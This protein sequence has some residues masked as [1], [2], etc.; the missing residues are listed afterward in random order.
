NFDVAAQLIQAGADLTI[1]NRE[2]AVIHASGLSADVLQLLL[3]AGADV[4]ARNQVG[5]TA[6]HK[7]RFNFEMTGLLLAAGADVS[8]QDNQGRTPLFDVN[9]KVAAQLI[10]AGADVNIQDS[11]GRTPLHQA[12]LEEGSYFGPE[13]VKLFLSKGAIADVKDYQGE[14]A[15]DIARRL[16]K[17]TI[18]QLFPADGGTLVN[19]GAANFEAA[20]P[21]LSNRVQRQVESLLQSARA[22]D[23]PAEMALSQLSQAG[24]LA[25]TISDVEIRDRLLQGIGLRSVELGALEEAQAIAQ[26]MNYETYGAMGRS[27]PELEQAVIKAY[28]QSGQTAQALSI[29]ESAPPNVR[30]QY[31]EAATGALV[32]QNLLAEAAA[33]LNRIPDDSIFDDN[34][35]QQAISRINQAYIGAGQFEAA[36]TLLQQQPFKQVGDEAS[37]LREIAL[38]AGRSGQLEMARAIAQ[39]IPE[40]YRAGTLVELAQIHQYQNRPKLAKR[41]LDEARQLLP[42]DSSRD[43]QRQFELVNQLATSYAELGSKKTARQVLADAEQSVPPSGS[44]DWVSAFAKIGAFDRAAQLVESASAGQRHKA[45]LSLATVYTDQGNY[46]QAITTLAQI[47]S[48]A[49]LPYLKDRQKL[50]DRIVEEALEQEKVSVAKRA[51]QVMESPLDSVPAWMKI[52]AFY[53]EK[54]ESKAAIDVLDRTLAIVEPLEK[55]SYAAEFSE[56]YKVSNAGLLT[57]I[58]QEYWAVGQREQAIETAEAAIASVRKFQSYSQSPL[59]GNGE[60]EAI[61]K[62]GRDWQ[63]PELQAAALGE[64]EALLEAATAN[65]PSL[66]SYP[67]Y[68]LMRLVKLA[69]NPNQAPSDLFNRNLARLETQIEQLPGEYRLSTL[70][71]LSLFYS[72]IDRPDKAR[73]ALEEILTLVEPLDAEQQN[74]FYSRVAS[75]TIRDVDLEDQFQIL[76][77]LSTAN[78]LNV[79]SE[80]TR[81]AA[82]EDDAAQTM[83]YFDRL[84]QLSDRT[85]SEAERNNLM[86]DLAYSLEGN[87]AGELLYSKPPHTPATIALLMR[88]PQHV[89]D[90]YQRAALW[91]TIFFDLPPAETA[92][93]YEALS[94]TLKEIPDGYNKCQFLWLWVQS[95]IN[96]RAFDQAAQIADLLEGEYRQTALGW[97]ET[98]R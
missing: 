6:L 69:Y 10:A 78:H 76:P 63:V 50:F 52:A 70:D 53:R 68:G 61:A 41:L 59:Y 40:N 20:D 96:Y 26:A 45:R 83:R 79:L 90:P 7:Q 51:A 48:S 27:R 11:L 60:L 44:N 55:L 37:G 24:A 43:W 39:Q 64:L 2:G 35:R 92:Q 30:A 22:A 57:A 67:P 17:P 80:A 1:Q 34:Y 16:N 5:Q 73:A 9:D 88:L 82:S 38:W 33:L 98:V 74:Y 81:R 71:A 49:L 91:M 58:A 97:V 36:Q 66:N 19:N 28:M 84:V 56:T 77:R 23:Q 18:V 8:I 13:L 85:Q 42:S 31:W 54:G 29:A 4:N 46:D 95:A 86:L 94:A 15:L 62:L 72:E 75:I 21:Q 32:D 93:A 3:D 87:S 47:P 65:D 14:T 12:V 89:S 25:Q